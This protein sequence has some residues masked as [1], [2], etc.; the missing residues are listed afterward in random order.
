VTNTGGGTLSWSASDNAT[1]LTLTPAAGNA[2]STLTV[3]VDFAGLAAGTYGG[4]I[5]VASAGVAGSPGIIPVTLT[6]ANAPAAW[7]QISLATVAAGFALPVH[8]TH[9]GDGSGRI[10]VVEQGGRIRLLDN[11]V[12]L[13]TPFL[14]LAALV[15]PRLVSGGEQGLLSVAFPPGFAAK[16]YFY[17]YYTRAADGAIVVARYLVSAGDANVAVPASEEVLLVIPHPGFTNHNG[18]QLAFGPDGYLYIGTGDGGGGGDTDNN[19]QNP[20]S[21]LGK[22]LRIDVESGSVPYRIPPDNPFVGSAVFLPEIWA[23]GLRNPWRFSFDRGTGDLYVGDVG[24]GLLEEIDVQPAGDPG[25]RNYGWNIMEGDRCYP[26]GTAD[27]NRTGLTLPV[28]VYGHTPECSVTGGHVYRGA[29]FP[30]LQ[31]IYLF[32]DYCSGRIWGMRQTGAAWDNAPLLAPA[33]N[34]STFGKDEA[35]NVYVANHANGDLWRIVVP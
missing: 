14:D 23:L 33:L 25:G 2:P 22:I 35:G 18:G 29:A 12:L 24:Q 9:S 11:G 31:G 3:S 32:G 8:V 28:L 1:W 17:V 4:A 20:A 19:A 21:M 5:T 30:S 7:P 34:I 16:R 6:V 27:C 26:P 13:P 10:F 15:P